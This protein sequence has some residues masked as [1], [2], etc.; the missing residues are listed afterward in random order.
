MKSWH[1]SSGLLSVSTSPL[2]DKDRV[3]AK[4][5]AA[6]AAKV[7][8]AKP[9]ATRTKKSSRVAPSKAN[10]SRAEVPADGGQVRE[11]FDER[12][13]K[14]S[15][16]FANPNYSDDDWVKNYARK[17]ASDLLKRKPK[18]ESDYIK[19]HKDSNYIQHI[20][21]EAPEVYKRAI[22][23]FRAL[24]EAERVDVEG[25]DRRRPAPTP[26]QYREREMRRLQVQA[27]DHIR[28]AV[29]VETAVQR[30]RHTLE[31]LE[32]ELDEEEIEEKLQHF[33]DMLTDE[34]DDNG[35]FA[36]V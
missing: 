36:S 35:T 13:R 19:F 30:Y 1:L 11:T 27:Q 32:L 34:G 24:T 18:I 10:D 6:E 14:L 33:R 31:E 22:W 29:E 8:P 25:T 17:Y 7:K 4:H 20:K 21:T 12:L 16:E 3:L 28:R 15:L 9:K 23:Q 5:Q 2:S 26:E